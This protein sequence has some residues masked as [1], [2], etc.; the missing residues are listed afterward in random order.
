MRIGSVGK[1]LDDVEVKIANDGEIV[2]KGPNVMM[3]YFKEPE[4][5]AEILIDAWF[6]TG[7]T[8]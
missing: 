5:T 4:M 7:D 8:G 3:S 2:V 6:H 1:I